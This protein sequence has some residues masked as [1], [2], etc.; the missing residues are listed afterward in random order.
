LNADVA[1]R[2]CDRDG[3]L[4]AV[5]HYDQEAQLVRPEVVIGIEVV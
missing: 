1:I 5:G 3:N 4:I 2:L